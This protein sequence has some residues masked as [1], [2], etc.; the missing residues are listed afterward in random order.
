MFKRSIIY[1]SPR[2]PAWLD[3]RRNSHDGLEIT[4]ILI[5]KIMGN[6]GK[7]TMPLLL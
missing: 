7:S 1:K 6:H 2:F 5:R 3:Y 4:N